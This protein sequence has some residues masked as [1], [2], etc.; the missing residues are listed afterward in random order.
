MRILIPAFDYKPQNGGVATYAYELASELKRQKHDVLV[1]APNQ[2]DDKDFDK[3]TDINTVRYTAPK[4][5][6]LAFK[7]IESIILKHT[8]QFKPD[9][10]FCPLWFP[11]A[12]CSH[13]ALKALPKTQLF[14]AAH[15]T[16]ISA[17]HSSTLQ[18]LRSLL[19]S[20]LKRKTFHAAKKIFA[21]SQ[22]TKNMIID[23]YPELL[24]KTIVVSNG[25]N[26][27]IYQKLEP[28]QRTTDFPQLLTVSRLIPSKGID[29]VLYSLPDV[30][31]K[32]PKL[33]YTIVGSGPDK[34]RLQDL[35]QKLKLENHAELAGFKKQ[36]ELIH[37][38][39]SHDLFILLSKS[40]PPHIEGFGL[41][42]LEAA[43]CGIPS[44]GSRSGGIPDAV[45]DGQTGWLVDTQNTQDVTNKL[46]EILK[47]REHLKSMGQSAWEN[48][49]LKT[50]R[51]S[52][53]KIL[54]AI[55]A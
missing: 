44:L 39:S 20:R 34:E 50:W 33:K 24:Q 48:A 49:Q 45:I 27:D 37:L 12:A 42:F 29:S 15:G 54:E 43:A 26:L 41:V 17:T 30:I 36:E 40:S 51:N 47:D 22:N 55:N 1:L 6:L 23:Q 21:V 16:E 2:P 9:V 7:T 5:A 52:T 38:Y 4:K 25:V 19:L 14:I 46:L 11:D 8:L 3:A 28:T 31:K 18:A 53:Q 32:Y 35:I 10:I 13:L